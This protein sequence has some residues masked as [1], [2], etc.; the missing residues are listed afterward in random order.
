MRPTA[1]AFLL[2][3]AASAHHGPAIA[4]DAAI[5][6]APVAVPE[7]KAVQGRVEA[8]DTIPARA[9]IGGSLVVLEVTEG[10]SVK[11]GQRIA[12]VTD[13]KLAFQVAAFDAQVSA[14]EAQLE[15]ARTDLQRGR[16][17]VKQG[18]STNQRVEQLQTAVDVIE[19]QADAARAQ[20]QV[21]LQQGAEGDIL[22]PAD[23]RVISVPVTRGAVIMPGEPVAMIASGGFY[24]RLAIPERHAA[25][26][27]EGAAIP[28][29]TP[30]GMGEGQL[31]KL[32]PQIENGR[33]I[34]DVEWPGLSAS[35]VGARLL[36]RVPIGERMALMLPAAALTTRHG[37]DFVRVET[38]SG[39]VE[40]AV[41]PGLAT[42]GTTDK[43]ML[44]IL[45]GLAAGETVLLPD[46]NP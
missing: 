32:Y 21:V 5:M 45:S 7:W 3:L 8:R 42:H 29:E 25:L 18:V 38:A 46:T 30:Q 1:L 11:A 37:T 20:R 40:R 28:V 31:A 13:E 43:P 41:V 26:L 27:E 22:A 34:A 14:L 24:L 6:V 17:L 33:V 12:A 36:V 15:N 44:E 23:G 39:P 16:D 2:F 19:G 4:A 35:F 10:D 9:R